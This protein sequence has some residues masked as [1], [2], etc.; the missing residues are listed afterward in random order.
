MSDTRKA[1]CYLLGMV[2]DGLHRDPMTERHARRLAK[3]LR[4]KLQ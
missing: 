3:L 1:T 4:I 2:E